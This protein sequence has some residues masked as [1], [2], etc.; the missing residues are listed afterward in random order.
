MPSLRLLALLLAIIPAAV[1][2]QGSAVTRRDLADAY[3]VIDHL[4]ITRGLPPAQ[5]AEW[6]RD[7]DRTT[8]AFFGGNFARVLR[9]MHDL[10]ARMVGDSTQ[11]SAS[12]QLLALRLR[13][14]PRVL[15]P[16]DSAVHLT[17]TVMYSDSAVTAGRTVTLRVLHPDGSV[18]AGGAVTI[19]ADA[20]VGSAHGVSIA[21]A[22]LALGRGRFVVEATLAGAEVTLRAPL[23]AM[24]IS[25]DSGRAAL[26]R[27]AAER[28]ANADPQLRAAFRARLALLADTPDESNSTQFLADPVALTDALMQEVEAIAAGRDPYRRT[29]DLWRV[30][31]MPNGEVPLRL[32]VPPQARTER[33]L[34][35]VIALHG[36]GADENMFLEG[37]GAGRLRDLADSIGF[38]LLSPL[39]TAF[40]REPGTLDS[41]LALMARS[42]TID[43]ERVYLIGHSMGGAAAISIASAAREQIRAAVVIAGAGAV[44]P[45]GRIAPTLFIAGE[46]DLV[47][48][49]TRVRVTYNQFTAA[50]AP[51]EFEQADGWGH[52]LIVGAHLERALG[53]LLQR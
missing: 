14:S 16:S 45:G 2:A 22:D 4:A 40:V 47:I 39:T 33:A 52:T 10:T 3:L 49:I 18:I 11:G 31:K 17:L 42:A 15:T 20:P 36:A 48:P 24:E 35:V 7:F 46:T 9:Q 37:Y 25:A 38:V 34:P 12:R 53:W 23:Y 41:A 32:Y 26:G 6:N 27:M 44:P 51:V 8:L 1:A 43:R 13:S 29:G 30:L 28:D 5:R 19:P 50:G 21:S